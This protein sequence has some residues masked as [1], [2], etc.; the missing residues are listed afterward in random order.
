MVDDK[1]V[2]LPV[3]IVVDPYW[4]KHEFGIQAKAMD[5]EQEKRKMCFFLV[6]C[7]I[8][9]SV[10]M[11]AVLYFESTPKFIAKTF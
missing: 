11:H 2:I 10:H 3:M 1:I 8:F 6:F 4:L 7:L 9:A 5:I